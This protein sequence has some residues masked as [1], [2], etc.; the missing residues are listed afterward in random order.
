MLY[1]Y[2]VVGV[3]PRKPTK[4]IDKAVVA[5]PLRGGGKMGFYDFTYSVILL[6]LLIIAIKK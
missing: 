6:I 2:Q 3:L 4:G 1:S 5:P